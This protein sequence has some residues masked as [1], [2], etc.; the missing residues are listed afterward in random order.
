MGRSGL[1]WNSGVMGVNRDSTPNYDEE[2]RRPE[3][4][5]GRLCDVEL[6]FAWWDNSGTLSLS[7]YIFLN[8]L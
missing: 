4:G 7:L 2:F 6:T 3:V 5:R 8:F 1:G